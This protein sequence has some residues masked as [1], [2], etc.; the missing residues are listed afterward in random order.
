MERTADVSISSPVAVVELIGES[1]FR[2]GDRISYAGFVRFRH[3]AGEFQQHHA[4]GVTQRQ[5]PA[6][7]LLV[8]SL[9][10]WRNECCLSVACRQVLVQAQS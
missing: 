6:K 1:G 5:R 10:L 8:K 7:W 2:S 4:R 9:I 3:R